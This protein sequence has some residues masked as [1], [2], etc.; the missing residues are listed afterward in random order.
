[1]TETDVASLAAA[2][3]K[4]NG[5]SEADEWAA[6]VVAAWKQPGDVAEVR[7]EE[8]AKREEG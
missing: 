1:M 5:H 4:A 3:A 2:I 6:K 7:A 8:T